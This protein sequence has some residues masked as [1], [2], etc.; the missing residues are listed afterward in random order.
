MSLAATSVIGRDVSER[1]RGCA[2]ALYGAHPL[3]SPFDEE[4]LSGKP[5]YGGAD[6]DSELLF[7]GHVARV[8]LTPGASTSST[9]HSHAVLRLVQYIHVPVYHK[10]PTKMD[11]ASQVLAQDPPTGVP[12]SYRAI[13]DHSGVPCSNLR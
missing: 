12:R 13:A 3:L 5:Q 9:D 7:H 10:Q 11:K 8:E 1:K 2:V 4:N 6:C